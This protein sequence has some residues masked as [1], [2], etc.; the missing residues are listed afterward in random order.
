MKW[1]KELE[2]FVM[3]CH[4]QGKTNSDIAELVGTSPSSIKHK[5]GRLKKANNEDRYK[6]TKEKLELY[7]RHRDHYGIN[8]LETHCGFG[9]LTEWYKNL[10]HVLAI[11]IV[12]DRVDH[13]DQQDWQNVVTLKADSEKYIYSIV[14]NGS[15]FDMIDIDPYGFPSRFFPHVFHL[16][17]D[18]ILFLTFPVMGVAQMNK[19]TIQH[20]KSFWDIELDDK[21]VYVEKIKKKLFDYAFMCKRSIEVLEVMKIDRIYRFAIKVEKESLLKIVGLEVNR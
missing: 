13:I 11:D 18:G 5:L 6:H 15:K 2:D 19:I 1:N 16:M 7:E 9:G 12:Q 8:I 14:A 21:D 20:Y 4:D 10:G 17:D 3:T